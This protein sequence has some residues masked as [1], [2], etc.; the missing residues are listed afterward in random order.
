MAD[1]CRFANSCKLYSKAPGMCNVHSLRLTMGSN[2][3]RVYLCSRYRWLEEKEKVMQKTILKIVNW[4]EENTEEMSYYHD[5]GSP[6]DVIRVDDLKAFL[7]D[8][9]REEIEN[10]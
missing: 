7:E 1:K 2:G 6:Y 5:P 8:L 3:G 10:G 9:I 4:I